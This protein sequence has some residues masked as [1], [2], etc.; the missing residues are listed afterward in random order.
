MNIKK[1]GWIWREKEVERERR[2]ECEVREWTE[3]WRGIEKT[4][5]KVWRVLG[6]RYVW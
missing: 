4:K 3:E 6:K 1:I 2:R 5:D